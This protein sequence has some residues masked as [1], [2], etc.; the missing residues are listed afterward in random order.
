MTSSPGFRVKRVSPCLAIA[1][2]P[3]VEKAY[4]SEVPIAST[5]IIPAERS[6][7]TIVVTLARVVSPT[8][9]PNDIEASDRA[10]FVRA[11]VSGLGA[12]A[13]PDSIVIP[14]ASTRPATFT[15]IRVLLS[16][17]DIL[18]DGRRALCLQCIRIYIVDV[19]GA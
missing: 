13:K 12:C 17:S 3:A 1:G 2:T 5:S 9:E 11:V 10:A 14:M 8:P 18:R 7:H 4:F 19:K 15:F 6:G 16:E